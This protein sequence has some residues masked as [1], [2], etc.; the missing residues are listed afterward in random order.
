V[1]VV[2]DWASHERSH[3]RSWAWR[4]RAADTEHD[5]TTVNRSRRTSSKVFAK[6]GSTGVS[7]KVVGSNSCHD[8]GVAHRL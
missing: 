3:E 1:A 5:I 4:T 2:A 8:L 6:F 7:D